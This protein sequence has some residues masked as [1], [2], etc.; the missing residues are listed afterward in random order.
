M[1]NE[2]FKW[3]IDRCYEIDLNGLLSRIFR[4]FESIQEDLNDFYSITSR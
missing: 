2:I 4:L 3:K 1:F